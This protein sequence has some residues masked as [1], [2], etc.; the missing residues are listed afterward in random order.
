MAVGSLVPLP[1]VFHA[2]AQVIKR[3]L[4]YTVTAQQ[5]TPQFVADGIA[6]EVTAIII[7]HT[8][9]DTVI[10]LAKTL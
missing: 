8:I 9:H 7:V 1:G 5:P 2:V 4:W 10:H 6:Q 3:G